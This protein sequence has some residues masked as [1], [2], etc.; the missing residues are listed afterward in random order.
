MAVLT[1]LKT[2]TFSDLLHQVLGRLLLAGQPTN[3]SRGLALEE[4]AV[5]LRLTNPLAWLSR[6]A[7]S[8]TLVSALGEL[9]WYL[10]G[11]SIESL[12]LRMK[13]TVTV[14]EASIRRGD[15][16]L[17]QLRGAGLEASEPI[18]AY[19]GELLS[20][21]RLRDLLTRRGS[22]KLILRRS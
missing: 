4:T 10:R 5:L 20:M 15:Q 13:E 11:V 8:S 2:A 19:P 6:N 9:C 12:L 22:Q 1:T 7:G 3:P 14:P 18:S 16:K 21:L 17:N